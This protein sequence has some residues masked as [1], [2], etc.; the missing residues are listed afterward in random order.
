MIVLNTI[1]SEPSLAGQPRMVTASPTVATLASRPKLAQRLVAD[2]SLPGDV[3]EKMLGD[4]GGI[5]SDE[6][7]DFHDYLQRL[8]SSEAFFSDLGQDDTD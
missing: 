8:E 6:R 3:V 4:P 1:T 7:I 5:A 2:A